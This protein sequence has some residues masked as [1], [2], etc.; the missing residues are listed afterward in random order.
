MS[1]LKNLLIIGLFVSVYVAVSPA[2][3]NSEFSQNEYE[4]TSGKILGY[5]TTSK[6]KS[7]GNCQEACNVKSNCE[8]YS[9]NTQGAHCVLYSSVRTI[10]DK[11]GAFTALRKEFN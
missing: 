3:A 1:L 10:R 2:F 4:I 5:K 6:F 9:L 7:A 8:A 11:K